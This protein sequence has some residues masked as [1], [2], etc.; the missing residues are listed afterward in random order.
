MK[1][2]KKHKNYC[3]KKCGSVEA[4]IPWKELTFQADHGPQVVEYLHKIYKTR[5]I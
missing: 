4:G 1:T 5:H 3:E 2:D